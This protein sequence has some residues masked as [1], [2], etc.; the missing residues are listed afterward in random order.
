MPISKQQT[1]EAWKPQKKLE[2]DLMSKGVNGISVSTMQ[3]AHEA[4]IHQSN[5]R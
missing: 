5:C 3:G 2:K 1:G 4:G